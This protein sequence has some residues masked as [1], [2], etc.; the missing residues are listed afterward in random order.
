MNFWQFVGVG[1][2]LWVLYDLLAGTAYSYRWVSRAREPV[3]YWLTM[4]L[5]SF[6]AVIT[7]AYG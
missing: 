5:W 6:V 7:L 3:H 1:L 4:A 2:V